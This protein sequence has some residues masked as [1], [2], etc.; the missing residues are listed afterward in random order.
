MQT[1]SELTQ[2]ESVLGTCPD[3]LSPL[4]LRIKGESSEM[5]FFY[6]GHCL[7]TWTLFFY[8]HVYIQFHALEH[9]S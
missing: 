3:T 5:E 4:E 7:N 9:L 6:V 8:E 2:A 1:L